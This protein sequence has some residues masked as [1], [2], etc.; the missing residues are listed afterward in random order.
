M[1]RT[2]AILLISP[3]AFALGPYP[4]A[5]GQTGSTALGKDDSRFVAWATGYWTPQYG[6]YVDAT[7]RTPQKSL[8]KALGDAM[9]IV[10]LG[11]GGSITMWFPHPICDGTGADFAVF[12]NSFSDGFLE[13]A[14]VEVS[15]DGVTFF[16]FP[17]ASLTTSAVGPFATTMSA[18]NIDGLAGKYRMAFGTPFDL[19]S[20]TSS[21]LLDKQNVRFVRLLDIIG[22]GATKDSSNRP[23]Y[24]PTPV[25]GSGGFDL[26]AIGVIHQNNGPVHVLPSV[27][28]A[29]AFRLKWETNPGS[30]YRVETATTLGSWTSLET[31]AGVSNRGLTERAYPLVNEPK[32]FWRI[33]RLDP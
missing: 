12:E 19:A 14:F 33:V 8:G 31:F 22:S 28:S 18:T 20:L 10:C 24:D 23:I 29:G 4:P 15:S 3:L 5:A 27:I 25:I 26:D 30:Q 1:L 32:R 2:L 11:N 7:W 6:A 13:L 9:D 17:S 16:R 21:S